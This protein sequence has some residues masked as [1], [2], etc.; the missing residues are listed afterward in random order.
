MK[1]FEAMRAAGVAAATLVMAGCGGGAAPKPA[2]AAPVTTAPAA[3]AAPAPVPSPMA[4]LPSYTDVL[5][6]FPP[7]AKMCR[8]VVYLVD[9]GN[10]NILN[11][12][13]SPKG[14][15][16][17]QRGPKDRTIRCTGTQISVLKDVRLEEKRY[18][19]G[20]RLTVDKSNNWVEVS[21]WN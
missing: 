17:F 4:P 14:T 12:S 2:P 13:V 11:L 10:S 5:K 19:R 20:A 8:T 16:P 6:T 18:K 21:G 7:T 3:A 15:E 1:R 9:V